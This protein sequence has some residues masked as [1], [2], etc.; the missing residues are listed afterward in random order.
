MQ[1]TFL[2]D[3]FRIKIRTRELTLVTLIFPDA[4]MAMTVNTGISMRA[5]TSFLTQNVNLSVP[6]IL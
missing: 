6:W 1:V 2:H 3:G 4:F 5:L